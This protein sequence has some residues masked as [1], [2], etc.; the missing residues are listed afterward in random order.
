MNTILVPLDG[1]A[2]AEQALPYV[3]GLAALLGAR[4]LLLNVIADTRDQGLMAESIA[5]T[6]GAVDPLVTQREREQRS[7]T[8]LTQHAES[9]LSSHA[10]LLQGLGIDTEIEVSYGPAAEVIVEIAE[11]QRV[12]MIVMATH[13]YS[14]L[15]RW[16]LGSV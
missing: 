8:T 3:R 11:G 14:G 1:S 12:A 7:L 9:Y 5:A 2:L 16:A 15:K 6:Y 4:V 10:A 13:G